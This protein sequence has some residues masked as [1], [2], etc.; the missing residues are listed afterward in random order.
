M[1][2]LQSGGRNSKVLYSD[3]VI[4]DGA[5]HC[6]GFTWD[7]SNRTLYVDGIVVAQDTQSGLTGST[8]GL[9]IGAGSTLAPGT[10]WSGLIDDVRIYSRAVLP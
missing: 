7:G 3:A 2:E 6:V 1:T 5:W 4:T 8:G 10:F 9:N